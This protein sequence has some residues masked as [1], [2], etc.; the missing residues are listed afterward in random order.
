MSDRIVEVGNYVTL[1]EYA[2]RHNI[3]AGAVRQKI[4]R[5]YLPCKRLGTG[6]RCMILIRAN[7]PWEA[8]KPGV[9]KGSKVAHRRTKA[10]MEEYRKQQGEKSKVEG[11]ANDT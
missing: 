9:K 1:E 3:T 6:R 8:H 4:K 10:E 2:K 11:D 5:G 7:E